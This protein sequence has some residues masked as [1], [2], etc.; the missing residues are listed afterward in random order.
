MGTKHVWSLALRGN[1]MDLGWER[2]REEVVVSGGE[3]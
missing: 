3:E 1:N 2:R